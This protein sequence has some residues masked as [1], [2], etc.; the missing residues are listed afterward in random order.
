MIGRDDS[1][2]NCL[3][4][5]AP[6]VQANV[7]EILVLTCNGCHGVWLDHAGLRLVA[8][9]KAPEELREI[10]ASPIAASGDED[11]AQRAPYRVPDARAPTEPRSC[12]F[13]QQALV[14]R[15]FGVHD[16]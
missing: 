10:A 2:M 7:P 4:C 12:L 14:K 15:V 6:L 11:P 8:Q 9:A 13:C 5:R 16:D 1:T 3:T